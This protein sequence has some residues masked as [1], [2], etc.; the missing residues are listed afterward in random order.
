MMIFKKAMP[1]RTFLRGVGASLALPLLDGMVPALASP[2]QAAL[3]QPKRF[4]IVYA[5][6]GMIMNKWT[7]ATTGSGFQMTPILEP[8]TDFRDNLLVLTGLTHI[9]GR[10]H[11]DESTGDHAR[12]GATYLTG[13]HPRKTEGADTGA[14]TTVDQIAAKVLG[15]ET[16]LASLE[17]CVDSPV[18]LGQ[19][20]A[21]Y[22]CA[23]MNTIC[24]STPTTP[25]PMENRPRAVFEH[26]FGDNETNEP[27]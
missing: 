13:V 8:L 21:G 26:L 18:L 15:R 17:L 3:W 27:G 11:P 19:C 25:V 7:P 4:S 2:R 16:Q 10:A 12:A 23:Y 22:T 20:E 14:A 9:D 6:N 1:R 5:A 24:W